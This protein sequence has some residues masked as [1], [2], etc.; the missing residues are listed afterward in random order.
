MPETLSFT[1]K[2]TLRFRSFSVEEQVLHDVF[3]EHGH[4][5]LDAFICH[6]ER[7]RSKGFGFVDFA[8][9]EEAQVAMAAMKDFPLVSV[10][11]F[12]LP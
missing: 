5:V 8:T 9:P 1:S 12:S 3:K 4:D 11:P 7:Y 10:N 2:L 6:D